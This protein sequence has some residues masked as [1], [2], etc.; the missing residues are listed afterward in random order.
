MGLLCWM[1]MLNCL[2]LIEDVF[3]VFGSSGARL[4]YARLGQAPLFQ[5]LG[6]CFSLRALFKGE[7]GRFRCRGLTSAVFSSTRPS[8]S[9]PTRRRVGEF[10]LPLGTGRRDRDWT[11]TQLLKME[12]VCLRV[13][14]SAPAE[15]AR[16]P[17]PEHPAVPW[18]PARLCLQG[19]YC[20]PCH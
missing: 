19:G 5:N 8:R 6:Q 13:F 9:G 14:A 11:T 3:F 20:G 15:R 7:L 17:R 2:T 12:D 1:L 4:G 10:G 16:E 18:A